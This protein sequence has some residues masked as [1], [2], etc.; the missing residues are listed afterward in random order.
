MYYGRYVDVLVEFDNTEP[1][2]E[3]KFSSNIN[4]ASDNESW[5]V[6]NFEI[7]GVVA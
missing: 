5:G 3:L 6:T 4:E 2:F 1:N 7:Y